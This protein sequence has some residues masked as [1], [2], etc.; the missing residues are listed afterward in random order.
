MQKRQRVDGF[1]NLGV[2]T[3]LSRGGEISEDFPY[4]DVTYGKGPTECI[5]E[6]SPAFGSWYDH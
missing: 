5:R 2:L 1:K 4:A 3:R 6:V